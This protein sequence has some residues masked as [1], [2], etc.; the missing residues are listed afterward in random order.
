MKPIKSRSIAHIQGPLIELLYDWDVPSTIVIDN[1]RSFTS[2]VV[3][4]QIKNLVVKIFKTPVHH[5]ESNGQIER[6]HSTLREI[7]RCFRN[8]SPNFSINELVQLAVHKYN[9]SIHSF[10]KDTP[11]N[12]Y[13]GVNIDNLLLPDF[14]RQKQE[15]LKKVIEK[16]EMKN[17]QIGDPMY[18]NYEPN[19]Y[20]YE[21]VNSVSKR[22]PKFKKVKIKED[23]LTHVIDE[24]GRKIHKSNLRKSVK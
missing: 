4:Q 1:E 18:H 17:L 5:S 9:N 15:N 20:A 3:E 10:T 13:T 23:H 11:K 22:D 2:E 24:R 16:F 21:K 7:I 6:V 19:S 12:L 8:S 14:A